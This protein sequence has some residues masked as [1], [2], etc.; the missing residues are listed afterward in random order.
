[1]LRSPLLVLA[2][3]AALAVPLKSDRSAPPENAG[4]DAAALEAWPG[5]R[6]LSAEGR[7]ES[8]LPTKWSAAEG[9]L[10]QTTVPGR[11][12]SSP[13]VFGNRVYVTTAYLTAR[14][15][16]LQE[17][18]RILTLTLVLVM[19]AL[20][21]RV[22]VNRSHPLRSPTT[23]DIGSGVSIMAAVLGLGVMGYGG[24][25]LFDF[26]RCNV[27]GWIAASVF[28]SLCLALIATSIGGRRQRNAIAL[29]SVAF[30]VFLLIA[31]PSKGFAFRGGPA[32]LR[33][34]ISLA[35][36]AIP[37]VVGFGIM[38][39]GLIRSRTARR[40]VAAC[41]AIGVV[42]SAAFLV[43]HL[44]IFRDDSFPATTYVPTLSPWWLLLGVP[45]LLDRLI[46]RSLLFTMMGIVCA[47]AAAV[48]ACVIALELLATRSPYLAYQL[49][50]PAFEWHPGDAV[51][52]TAGAALLVYTLWK[53]SRA[54]H[55]PA[56]ELHPW[57]P[58]SLAVTTLLLGVLFFVHVNY[59]QGQ[60][61]MVRAIVALDRETGDLQWTLEGLD[62][63]QPPTDG[64]NSPAT[65]TP[66]TDGRN[67]CAYFGT[68]GLMCSDSEGRL[69]W[70]RRDVAYEGFYGVGF[71]PVLVE[72][73]L[74]IA[75][76]APDGV[77]HVHALDAATGVTRWTRTFR[78]TPTVTGNNRTPIVRD[79]GGQ[80]TLILWGMQ[81]V[82]GVSLAS[83]QSLWDYQHISDGDLVSSAVSDAERLY[84][85]SKSGTVALSYASLVAGRDPV[86]WTSTARA[87]CVSPVLADGILF[88]VTDA[89][90][91]TA[92]DADTG[93]TLWRSRLPGHYFASLLA[94][95]EGVYFTNSDG[96]TT[97]VAAE[98]GYRMIA[99]NDLG[100]PTMASMAAARG[101]LFARAGSSIFALGSR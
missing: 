45:A 79:S 4:S 32:S 75:A 55:E 25:G 99:Q 47:A 80:K 53:A 85:S 94:S 6:G 49:G 56:A 69:A 70:S 68:P 14:G 40:F 91:A 64:R 59:V 19:A 54:R 100:E 93:E 46:Q 30:A 81:Y 48:V 5:F 78:T 76:D 86:L 38:S 34:Q 65:P 15:Q 73:T 11:G 72:G 66:V 21:L 57:L 71:S 10:W 51:F 12:H 23:T 96:L 22:V 67:V 101:V 2:V 43:W 41:V 89:G 24:D 84:L 83:G 17:S 18:L 27:R 39:V 77:A 16:A 74:V 87:N 8:T 31:F 90:I 26:A 28:A 62:V 42:A 29:G 98:A 50:T 3:L 13:I 33:M 7:S 92:I 37:I 61:R 82:R 58:T 88:T 20:A 1:M 52:W 36:A 63:A 60:S 9:I 97:V 95:R 35:A 44:L